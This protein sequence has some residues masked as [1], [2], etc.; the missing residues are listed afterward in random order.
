VVNVAPTSLM[1]KRQGVLSQRKVEIVTK[2][3]NAHGEYCFYTTFETFPG[4][5]LQ[6]WRNETLFLVR[7]Q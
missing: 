5:S 4:L 3:K 6:V 1:V 7:K 2:S